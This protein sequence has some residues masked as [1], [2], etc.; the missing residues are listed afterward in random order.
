MQG[1]EGT[2]RAKQDFKKEDE[3]KEQRSHQR[4]SETHSN[5]KQEQNTML[6][7]LKMAEKEWSSSKN[8]LNRNLM[9]LIGKASTN[10]G[11]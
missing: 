4:Q 1:L 7:K 8:L 6:E 5:E 11:V 3:T 2:L 10:P 9:R